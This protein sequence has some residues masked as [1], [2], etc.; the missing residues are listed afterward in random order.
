MGG[1]SSADLSELGVIPRACRQLFNAIFHREAHTS[2]VVQC[3]YLEVYNE[4]CRDLLGEGR[5]LKLREG[6]RGVAV[7][8]LT[9]DLTPSAD[10]V[11]NALWRGNAHRTV[12]AMK[13]NARSSRGHAIL[14][15]CVEEL[16]GDA[17][18]R[19]GKLTLVD[20]AGMESSKKSFPVEGASG[21]PQR[22]EEAKHINT[23]LCALASVVAALS[24]SS[25][26]DHVPFR[27]SKLT[28]L[29]RDSLS[30]GPSKSAVFVMLRSEARHQDETV[31][32]LRFAQRAKA[33]QVVV[34]PNAVEGDQDA[35]S[36][37]GQLSSVNTELAAAR[38]LIE[39]LEKDLAQAESRAHPHHRAHQ[40]GEGA[41]VDSSSYLELVFLRGKNRQ[42]RARTAL[43]RFMS[44]MADSK[45]SK[46]SS[47]RDEMRSRADGLEEALEDRDRRIAE[48]ETQ[49]GRLRMSSCGSSSASLA[50][51]LR[52]PHSCLATPT[53]SSFGSR[54]ISGESV[55]F[56]RRVGLGDLAASSRGMDALHSS[57][58]LDS[59]LDSG[60]SAPTPA[61]PGEAV[62]RGREAAARL[63]PDADEFDH[64]SQLAT[65]RK[66]A[67]AA[68][69]F[70][71]ENV[72][73]DQLF[74]DAKVRARHPT[75][76]Y[77]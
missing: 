10:D 57:G 51:S 5:N 1:L 22:R 73:I 20:L 6:K 46:M 33:V 24:S 43:Q 71:F 55:R 26:G 29:L 77:A 13:M 11:M 38:S 3:G 76:P 47:E 59:G 36:L 60:L 32:T 14:Y 35:Q 48:L 28:R 64:F 17:G 56:A 9:F 2:I 49:C 27:D 39:T 53:A 68:R 7:D 42:L 12:A 15:V 19:M 67:L 18:K 66:L 65:A 69:G 16:N 70:E 34:R 75:Q 44:T 40:P 25:G 58:L 50:E 45:L 41:D 62:L 72:F 31:A 74:D 30:D 8:G 37:R 63:P 52:A 4:R 21:H 61:P 23:S 54:P